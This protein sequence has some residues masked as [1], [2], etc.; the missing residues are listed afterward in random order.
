M[1]FVD[2]KLFAV[3]SAG[4]PVGIITERDL[5]D[6]AAGLLEQQLKEE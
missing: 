5:M 3:G 6:L 4:E 2:S 1:P